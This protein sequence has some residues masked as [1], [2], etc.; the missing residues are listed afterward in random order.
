MAT[1]PGISSCR[2]LPSDSA[3][4][5]V[6]NGAPLNVTH[7]GTMSFSTNTDHIHL[8][9]VLVCPSLI[10]N[11]VSVRALTRDNPVTIEFDA[12]GFSI[13]DL[14]TR[15]VLLRCDSSGELYPFRSSSTIHH[16]LAVDTSSVLWHARLGHLSNGSL[17]TFLRSFP[18]SCSRLDNHL[19]HACLLGKQV[20]L[21]FTCSNNVASRPFKLLHCDVWTSPVITNSG[22]KY[23]LVILDDHTHFVRTFPLRNKSNVLPTIICF[24]AFVRTQF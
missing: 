6:G 3:H 24:H 1:H 13:K 17:S 8:N 18:F 20:R 19:C 14:R 21:P 12:F 5:I 16:S 11:L 10:K 22:Y 15:T 23:Y 4:V 9:N 7:T 2:P